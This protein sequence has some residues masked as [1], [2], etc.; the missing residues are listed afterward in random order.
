[1]FNR[2]IRPE[3]NDATSYRPESLR[4]CAIDGTAPNTPWL[5]VDRGRVPA[6]D[7]RLIAA[8]PRATRVEAEA[9]MIRNDGDVDSP[10]LKIG[11]RI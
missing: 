5:V 11:K 7:A 1:M 4:L 6:H 8:L 2:I 3:P 9:A 10:P